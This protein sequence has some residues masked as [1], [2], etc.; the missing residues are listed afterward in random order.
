MN[1]FYHVE[2]AAVATC[3]DC[4]RG[5]CKECTVLYQTPICSECNMKRVKNDK[6]NIIRI[7]LPSILLFLIGIFVGTSYGGVRVGISFGWIFAG[8]PWGWK[9]VTF[10]QPRMFLFLPLFGWVIYFFLKISLSIFVGMIAFPFGLIKLIIG[11]VSANKKEKNI[12]ENLK[13]S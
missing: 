12:N 7:Y 11:I 1:C 4:E 9:F 10:I 6:G 8:A 3:V 2:E 13:S 5:L